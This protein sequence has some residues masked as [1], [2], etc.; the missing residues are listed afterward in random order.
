[1]LFVHP[2]AKD[3]SNLTLYKG[4]IDE[5]NNVQWP[6]E[7]LVNIYPG[8]SVYSDVQVLLFDTGAEAGIFFER[9]FVGNKGTISFTRVKLDE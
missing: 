8:S 7:K 2:D 6:T 4:E 3:R 5:F 9:D 1:M